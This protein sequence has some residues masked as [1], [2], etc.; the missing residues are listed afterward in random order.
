MAYFLTLTYKFDDKQIKEVSRHYKID[1]DNYGTDF[2]YKEALIECLENFSGKKC[3]KYGT[4]WDME[5]N[6]FED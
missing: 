1:P 4:L 3:D 2:D 6:I 5:I